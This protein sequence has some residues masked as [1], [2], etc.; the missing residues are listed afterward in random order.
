MSAS[1]SMR[2]PTDCSAKERSIVRLESSNLSYLPLAILA[3]TFHWRARPEGRLRSFH[4][5]RQRRQSGS[6]HKVGGSNPRPGPP[7]CA[8][9]RVGPR[10]RP[11]AVSRTGVVNG[12]RHTRRWGE[13]VS[14]PYTSGRRVERSGNSE[15]QSRRWS[16]SKSAIR[17]AGSSR[18]AC[19]RM[20]P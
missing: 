1:T 9:V 11:S 18:G 13:S 2:W 10:D 6:H 16:T 3:P 17:T 4:P 20:R 12:R 8:Q 15:S 19:T 14:E 5:R 7:S